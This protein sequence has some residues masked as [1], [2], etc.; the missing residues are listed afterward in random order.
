LE[1]PYFQGGFLGV[2]IF[3]LI[4]GYLI[5]K[6]LLG[7]KEVGLEHFYEGRIRRILPPL[8]V[9][10]FLTT[11]FIFFFYKDNSIFKNYS[12]SLVS[13]I[14]FFSNFF[15]NHSVNYFNNENV[16]HPL[17][18]TWS[19]SIE[20]QFYL[21]YPI[22]LIF[23]IKF[24]KDK[25]IYFFVLII[26]I[27]IIFI[28]F[29]GNLKLNFPFIEDKFLFFNQSF[30]FNFFSPLARAWEFL[31]GSL[32]YFISLK[33]YKINNW[34]NFIILPISYVLILY[35]ITSL[36]YNSF[37]PNIYTLIPLIG[38]SII[39]LYENKKSLTYKIITNKLLVFLGIISYSLYLWH[40]SI[41]S[42]TNYLYGDVIFYNKIL[43][44]IVSLL[45][46]ILS[47]SFIETPFRDRKTINKVFLYIFI[48]IFVLINIFLAAFIYYDQSKQK[49]INKLFEN[50]SFAQNLNNNFK[51]DQIKLLRLNN[52]LKSTQNDPS[53]INNILVIGDS[54]GVDLFRILTNNKILKETSNINFYNIEP[55]HFKKN[56]LDE[57]QK[58]DNFFKSDLYINANI[59]I[60][61]DFI[62]PSSSHKFI[63]NNFDGIKYL[64]S[65]NNNN[66]KFILANQS[67]FFLGN[68]DPVRT[69]ILKNYLDSKFSEKFIGHAIYKL[70][71]KMFF[72]LNDD[73]FN[74]AHKEKI[75]LFDLFDIFCDKTNNECKFKTNKNE[76][77]FFDASHITQKGAEYI[78]QDPKLSKLIILFDNN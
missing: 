25:I 61:S 72:S 38:S 29:S 11:I 37:W 57:M 13:S 78:S 35:S 76:L 21:F 28:Q 2:D 47:W 54:H 66:K 32:I 33:K 17:L 23:L 53:K 45:I 73:I 71:P 51:D 69:V 8:L 56:N 55:H 41:I 31:I 40:H 5:T 50:Y 20:E 30:Y 15:F 18:H 65:V 49:N 58:V 67:P 19:L 12:L 43:I 39:L 6:I 16:W 3:F 59:I 68:Y 36:Y 70:I 64:N 9:Y 1:I 7:R 27:N 77:I 22:I 24:F 4:S 62:S 42:I 48:I 14:F 63:K 52:N 60:V 46:S 26:L 74:F 34:I 44:L 75:I 10:L